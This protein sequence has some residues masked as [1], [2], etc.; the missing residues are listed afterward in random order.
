[1]TE[2][3]WRQLFSRKLATLMEERRVSINLLTF[4]SGVSRATLYRY[5]QGIDTPSVRNVLR[6]CYALGIDV[7]ELIDFGEPIYSQAYLDDH[8]GDL[9][10]ILPPD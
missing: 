7:A 1:M 6:V 5:L 2:R 3:L 9:Y 8:A 10:G 4:Q